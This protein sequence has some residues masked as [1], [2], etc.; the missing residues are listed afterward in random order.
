[1]YYTNNG[2]TQLIGNVLTSDW[3]TPSLTPW[4]D[5][6]SGFRML[7][8]CESKQKLYPPIYFGTMEN[9]TTPSRLHF[10]TSQC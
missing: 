5:L 10:C 3:I 6:N 8:I 4:T 1:M 9:R 7:H 2:A